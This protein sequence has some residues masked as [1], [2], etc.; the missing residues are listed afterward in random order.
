MTAS[1]IAGHPVTLDTAESI[2]DGLIPVRPGDLTFA[3]AEAFVDRIVTVTE[4]QIARATLW[5]F[6]EA[7]QVVEPSGAATTAAGLWPDPTSP[8]ADRSRTVVAVVSGGNV[9]LE[10]LVALQVEP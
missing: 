8:L 5:L 10:T 1:L 4:A 2:G 6:A 7:K 3:H 9:S